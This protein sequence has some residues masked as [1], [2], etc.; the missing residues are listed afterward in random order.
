MDGAMKFIK[1][2]AIASLIITG[3]AFVGGMAVGVWRHGSSLGSAVKLYGLLAIGDGLVSQLPALVTSIAAGLT[4]TRVAEQEQLGSLGQEVLAQ[5]FDRPRALYA[6]SASLCMLAIVP[7]LPALPFALLALLTAARAL[8]FQRARAPAAEADQRPAQLTLELG[9]QLMAAND[10]ALAALLGA[11]AQYAARR[12]GIPAPRTAVTA[13]AAL[14]PQQYVLRLRHAPLARGQARDSAELLRVLDAELR[15]LWLRRARELLGLEDAQ[16]LLDRVGAYSPALVQ[17]VVPRVLSLAQL[18]EIL[19]RLLDENVSIAG[20]ERVLEQLASCE[21]NTSLDRGLELARRALREEL[22][23]RC[24]HEGVLYVHELDPMIEDALRDATQTIARDRVIALAPEHAHDVVQAVRRVRALHAV[25]PVL[26][27]QADV[28][29]SLRDVLAH[30][31]P[32][33]HVLTY[34]EL[35]PSL[36]VERREPITIATAPA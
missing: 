32:E 4:V 33:V 30:E 6:V 36:T 12:F 25:A 27:T 1:G 9:S 35:P 7:G 5:L 14:A 11:Q 8:Y 28:R 3:I 22:S 29:R 17:S 24:L 19:R 20:L 10:P 21:P 18:A 16:R 23:E 26:L 34:T 31:L 15:E 13:G 2:D